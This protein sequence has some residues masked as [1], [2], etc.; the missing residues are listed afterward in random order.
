MSTQFVIVALLE[1]IGKG[2]EDSTNMPS[3]EMHLEMESAKTFKQ[4]NLATAQRTMAN[5]TYN[6]YWIPMSFFVFSGKS[7]CRKEEERER[8]GDASV[9]RAKADER[10]VQFEADDESHARRDGAVQGPG[11]LEE[12][13]R[14]HSSQAHGGAE[15]TWFC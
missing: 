6:H 12:G 9:I 14:R 4:K 11:R 10:S 3:A 1:H 8:T 5:P 2:I 13:L 15:I 7:S